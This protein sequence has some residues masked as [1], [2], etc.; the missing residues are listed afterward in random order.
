M[1]LHSDKMKE[2]KV[3]FKS[4]LKK[5]GHTEK[6]RQRRSS[7]KTNVKCKLSLIS[8]NSFGNTNLE[9][10][11]GNFGKCTLKVKVIQRYELFL[12]QGNFGMKL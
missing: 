12:G 5:E 7:S 1:Y 4:C 9:N 6:K 11:C 2:C 10:Y 3:T 8:N